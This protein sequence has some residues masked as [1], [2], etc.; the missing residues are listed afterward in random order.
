MKTRIT[1]LPSARVCKH[2]AESNTASQIAS[3]LIWSRLSFAFFDDKQGARIFTVYA[4]VSEV[5]NVLTPALSV[6]AYLRPDEYSVE[7]AP[8]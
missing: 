6:E 4:E 8:L 3:A 2:R 1:V 7:P 5:V